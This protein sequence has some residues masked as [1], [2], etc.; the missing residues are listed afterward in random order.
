MSKIKI[1]FEMNLKT[2]VMTFTPIE[3]DPEAVAN[4]I[5]PVGGGM[6]ALKERLSYL[7]DL[8]EVSWVEFEPANVFIGFSKFPEDLKQI[9]NA[10]AVLGSKSFGFDI[11]V[12]ACRADDPGWRPGSSPCH[13]SVMTRNGVPQENNYPLDLR[14]LDSVGMVH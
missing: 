5:K 7:K 2:G 10:A 9:M 12:W 3:G 11:Y 6:A 4:L 8:P 13:Y 1:L 14:W